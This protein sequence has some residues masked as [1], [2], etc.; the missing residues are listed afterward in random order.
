M[1]KHYLYVTR[2]LSKKISH[3]EFIRKVELTQ[4]CE[5]YYAMYQGKLNKHFKKWCCIENNKIKYN[6]SGLEDSYVQNY[7]N[8]MQVIVN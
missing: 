5:L 1:A 7:L 8:Q 2:C 6:D 4:R 3:S